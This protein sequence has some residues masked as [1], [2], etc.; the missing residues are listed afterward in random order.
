MRVDWQKT[1]SMLFCILVAAGAFF[2]VGK[3]VITIVMPF[4]IAW[5]LALFLRPLA[6]KLSEKSRIPPRLASVAVLL[7]LFTALGLLLFWGVNRL[8]EELGRLAERISSGQLR[9]VFPKGAL[10]VLQQPTAL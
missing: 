2:L 3:Y 1:A 6:K 9:T 7:L 10:T 4:L 8:V 5:G